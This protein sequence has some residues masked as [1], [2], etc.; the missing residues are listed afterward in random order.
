VLWLASFL[1]CLKNRFGG[2]SKQPGRHERPVSPCDD[3]RGAYYRKK[4]KKNEALAK[5]KQSRITAPVD[6]VSPGPANIRETSEHIN[7]I[8]LQRGDFEQRPAN[9]SSVPP[10]ASLLNR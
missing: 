7:F 1:D 8:L 10:K 9:R 6:N 4:K 2:F 3:G 5:Y